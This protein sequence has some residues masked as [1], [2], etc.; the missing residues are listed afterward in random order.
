M[1][2]NTR[3]LLSVILFIAL[4]AS[5]FSVTATAESTEEDYTE[6]AEGYI[7]EDESIYWL[8]FFSEGHYRISVNGSG[9]IPDYAS[10][11]ATPWASYRDKI[12][13]LNIVDSPTYIGSNAFS[14]FSSLENIYFY[15]NAPEFGE[16]VFADVT[17]Y[18]FVDSS[19]ETWTDYVKQDYGGQLEWY[20]LINPVDGG[21]T[22]E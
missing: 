21:L 4:F 9:R 3:R 1:K 13:I 14:G 15:G 8:V 6:L 12:T 11:A 18:C 2:P 20:D 16:N 17:S 7:G 5:L 10:P 19:N 22:D